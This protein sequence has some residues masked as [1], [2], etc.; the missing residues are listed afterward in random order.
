MKNCELII[1]G[2]SGVFSTEQRVT[3]SHQHVT[4]Q[5][6]KNVLSEV[7]QLL[8]KL[9]KKGYVMI[10]VLAQDEHYNSTPYMRLIVEW[11]SSKMEVRPYNET[12]RN[13][14]TIEDYSFPTEKNMMDY[15]M[16]EIKQAIIELMHPIP[17]NNSRY[18]QELAA[19]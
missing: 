4:Q 1:S 11:N 3:F 9:R 6:V 8:N 7:R 16:V 15:T 10:D 12:H 14:S 18:G 19:R 17:A 13:F 5:E 2:K